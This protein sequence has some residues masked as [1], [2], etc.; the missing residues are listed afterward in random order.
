MQ[1]VQYMNR[2]DHYVILTVSH[3]FYYV[4]TT[5]ALSRIRY[6]SMHSQ[7]SIKICLDTLCQHLVVGQNPGIIHQ[8]GFRNLLV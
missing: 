6:D 4:M 2:H 5:Q 8:L 1:T 3:L 7:T